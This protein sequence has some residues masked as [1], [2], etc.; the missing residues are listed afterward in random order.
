MTTSSLEQETSKKKFR[1][2]ASVMNMVPRVSILLLLGVVLAI[3]SPYFLKVNNL[4]NILSMASIP[5]ILAIGET[6]VVLTGNIDLSLGA[7]FSIGGVVPAALMK[8]LNVPVPIAV[9]AGVIAGGLMGL[10]N[11]ALVSKVKLPSFIATYGLKVAI[12]GI[13]VAILQGYVV[14]GF[15][16]AFRFLGIDRVLNIPVPIYVAVIVFFIV[17]FI[18]RRSTFGRKLYATGANMEA[19][20]LSGIK[21]DNV[22]IWTFVLAGALAALAGIIQVSRVNS[23]HAFLGDTM[24]LPAIAAVVLGGTSMFGG[25]GGVFGTV[26]GA[27][28]MSV[29]DNGLNLVGAPSILQ[30]FIVGVIILLAI[31][32]DQTVRKVTEK[33]LQ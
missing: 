27:L 8:F 19:A 7:V 30:Q 6:L 20:R 16:D 10:A 15:P 1:I 3:M 14:Y 28:I 18:L 17:W 26:I 5:I 9:L 33:Q 22:V 12:T 11:G 4:I 32:I 25:I 24:L 23:S 29:I 31:V 21:V 2:S 13:A